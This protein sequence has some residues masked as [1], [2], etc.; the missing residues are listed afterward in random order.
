MTDSDLSASTITDGLETRLIGQSVLYFP[1][2]KSTMEVARE[3]VRRG[4]GEGTVVATDEQTA[5][6]GRLKRSWLTPRGGVAL[7]IVLKP[8]I[9]YLPYLIMLASVAVA[10]TIE[11]VTGLKVQLKWPNDVL[12]NGRKVCGILIESGVRDDIVDYAI[13]GIGI[14]ANIKIADSAAVLL[15]DATSLS[16]ELGRGV[17]R[18]R[19]VRRLL[20]ELDRLYLALP[21]GESIYAEW[22]DRL[23]TLGRKVGVAS[24]DVVYQ[25]IAESVDRDGSLNLRLTDGG[26]IRVSAG[27]VSLRDLKDDGDAD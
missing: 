17:S 9:D 3:E 15:A 2:L 11:A 7:S 10:R 14:N 26:L 27:D 20:V 8:A 5:G 1:S 22:R 4:A 6:R 25:G 12:V 19:L 23:I 16:D 18:L 21:R 13:I 24:G